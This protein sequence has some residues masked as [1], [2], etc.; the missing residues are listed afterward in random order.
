MHPLFVSLWHYLE[1]HCAHKDKH[2]HQPE[3]H[4]APDKAHSAKLATAEIESTQ[5]KKNPNEKT[6][7]CGGSEMSLFLQAACQIIT[8]FFTLKIP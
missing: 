4:K 5:K 6:R 2:Q 7:T 3:H 8:L 1:S